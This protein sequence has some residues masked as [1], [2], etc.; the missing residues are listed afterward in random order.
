MP[1]RRVDKEYVELWS[2]LYDE[3]YDAVLT[4]VGPSVRERGYYDRND[5]MAVGRWKAARTTP[6][7]ESNTEQML[8]DVTST[9]FGAPE[10]IRHRVMTLLTGVQ[11]PIA[12]ALLTAWRPDLY[13]VIDVR[14]VKSLVAEGALEESKNLPPY[15]TYLNICRELAADCQCDLRTLDRALWQANGRPVGDVT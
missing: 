10:P 5:F 11:V 3:T 9:A 6:L 7:L 15:M 2:A 14:A 13:T 1:D 4:R 8:K 12:S